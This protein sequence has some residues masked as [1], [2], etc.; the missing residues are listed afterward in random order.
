MAV[1][2]SPHTARLVL[3]RWTPWPCVPTQRDSCWAGGRH[4]RAY[5]LTHSATRACTPCHVREPGC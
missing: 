5:P 3:C 4:G 2:S 1:R